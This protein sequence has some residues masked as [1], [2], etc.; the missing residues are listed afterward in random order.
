MRGPLSDTFEAL[1]KIPA[2]L[3]LLGGLFY[4]VYW[5]LAIHL[6]DERRARDDPVYA[7]QVFAGV[8]D[9]DAVLASRAWHRRGAEAWDC[10]YAVVSLPEDASSEPPTSDA[11]AWFLRYGGSW[12]ET[13]MP[14]LAD[15]TRDAVAFCARYF[16]DVL[17]TRLAYALTEGGSWH[18]IGSVGETVHIY[19]APQRIAARIRY[20]D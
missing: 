6:P 9:Y 3:I 17:N 1:I 15:R 11:E 2:T 12:L 19:S 20:G 4:G 18:I 8:L 16:D 14:P 5:Y 10:T 13:P 7:D